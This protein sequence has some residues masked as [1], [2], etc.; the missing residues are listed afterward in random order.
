MF[1]Q[2][3]YATDSGSE[4]RK[5]DNGCGADCGYGAYDGE[6]WGEGIGYRTMNYIFCYD[7]GSLENQFSGRIYNL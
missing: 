5:N 4:S 1:D 3:D 7:E 6:G 2:E